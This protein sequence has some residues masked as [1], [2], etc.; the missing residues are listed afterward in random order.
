MDLPIIR[1]EKSGL[2]IPDEA[3]RKEW[4]LTNGIGGY[5]S[6][7]S[8]GINTR[9]YHGLLVAAFNPPVD[10]WVLLTKL[11]EEISI[12]NE[13]YL[14]GSNEFRQG[15]NPAGYRF[16]LDFSLNPFPTYRY[17]TQGVHVQKKIFMPYKKNAVII[18]YEAFN[19]R[20]KK[21]SIRSSPLIN[22]RHF[23]NVTNKDNLAWSFV[24]KRFEQGIIV[25]PSD[26]LSTLILSSDNGEGFVQGGNWVE[27]IYFR[28]DASRGESCMDDYFRP[29]WFEFHV[30]PKE[31][32]RFHVL[33]TAG[34]SEEE[35]QNLFSSIH[36]RLE[37]GDILFG[38]E[39][40]RRK[41]LLTR[42][43]ERYVDL[44]INDW[45]RWLIQATDSF[46]V[47]RK[48]TKKKSV[49]AGYHWF[50][51]W[52][53]DS[54]ISLPGLTLV[55]G[56]FEDAKEILLTFTHYCHNGIIPNRFPDRAGDTPIYNTV[57]ATLWFFNAVLQ[58]VKYTGDFDFVQRELWDT[59]KIIIEKH[60]QG[61]IYGIHMEDDGL[62]AHGP[63]ITW[64]DATASDQFVTPRDGKAVEIQALWYN[65]LK[66]MG[67]LAE[68][69]NQEEEREKYSSIAK[70]ASKSFNEKFW[71]S[72]KRFLFDTVHEKQ[73]DS[74]LRPNQ[75]IAAAL[76]FSMLDKPKREEIVGI[77]WK[78]LWGTY[79]LKTLLGDDP[80]YIG[81]Y[82]GGWNH[83]GKA[84]H[85]GTVWAW[86]IGPFTTAFLKAKDYE[87][88]W[89]NFAFKNFL[90]PLFQ[91]EILKAGLGTISEI[92]DGNHPHSSRGCI[93][94]AWS[95]AEPLRA[96]VEDV[97]LKR[98][99]Y[100]GE[101]LGP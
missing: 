67:L 92:F 96:F 22:S 55:T 16:L 63:Q 34:K 7:T 80:R 39:L 37:D 50:E 46:L 48:S 72:E 28:V 19:P 100:E 32:K 70:K 12:G 61:T 59:L 17:I 66:T 98:P 27:K 86:H 36:R 18:A 64:M 99:P 88:S 71:N 84:Y 73:I 6:S 14:L 11:D 1:L 9:K 44:E 53:R 3:L 65:A 90:Q 94:Q 82:V 101:A 24:Q 2:S 40:E 77:V 52:G 81:E 49:I 25:Q 97:A 42:F 26:P 31:K 8:L 43:Q 33:A 51:D 41:S 60:V 13:T 10:R 74:S 58:F 23:H 30:A 75:V 54:L 93:A 68:R 35:A 5:A 56:R 87:E 78:K 21:V 45:L 38:Q 4:I 79:G 47:D 15:I 76:D 29:G 57:D 62:I 69:F 95:V 85:N 89:R 83:R 91:E 20:E